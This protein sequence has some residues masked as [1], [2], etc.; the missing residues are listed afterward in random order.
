METTE[1]VAAAFQPVDDPLG[2][3]LHALRMSGTFYCRSEFS[4]PWGLDL[5]EMPD[6]LM[7]HVI[8]AGN[9][10]IEVPGA[11][12]RLLRRGDFAMIPHGQG[13][14]LLSDPD[15]EAA[16]LFDLPREL[17]SER[18]EILRHGGGGAPTTM[19]CGA[20]QFDH[21]VAVRVIS[22][23]PKLI[24]MDASGPE[25]EWIL[26]AI[27]F[28]IAEA[29]AMRPGGET[30]ITRVSD[31]LV[32]QAIRSWLDKDA[33]AKTGWLGA[34]QDPQI[35][36]AIAFIHRNPVHPWTVASLAERIG[37]SRSGFAG[38]F[39]DLVGE[40]PMHYVR[41]WRM[42]VAVTWLKENDEPI[43]ELAEK[44][45]YQSEAAFNR[46]FKKFIGQ[47]P[48]KVRRNAA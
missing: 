8:T 34:L 6:C 16:D 12:P 26:S 11:E 41:R 30:V 39:M 40:P 29:E 28:M 31:I 2:E 5:P 46:A 15:A 48:G 25:N 32:I 42:H 38:R 35:G 17:L 36:Q 1:A 10:W 7:F 22:M 20:V 19:I 9:C 37:M 18:Y 4:A 3:A 21:P 27:R 47:T 24:I 33:A 14:R 43:G 44:L 45:G 23:L 13:H